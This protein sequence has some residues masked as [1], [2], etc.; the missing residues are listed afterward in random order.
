MCGIVGVISLS[1]ISSIKEKWF[2]NALYID[3]LRGMH[4]TGILSINSAFEPSIIKKALPAG[5][6]LDL[7]Q[8][9][10]LFFG[11]HRVLLGHN[12]FASK[13]AINNRNAHPFTHDHITMVHNGTLTY[14]NNLKGCKEF[15]VDSEALCYS[16][17]VDG[18]KETLEKLQG[19]FSIVWWDNNEKTMNF[20]RNEERPMYTAFC[21]N[22]E[23]IVFASEPEIITWLSSRLDTIFK[24]EEPI[25]TDAGKL[26]TLQIGDN[27]DKTLVP[28]VTELNLESFMSEQIYHG[29]PYGRSEGRTYFPKD[30]KTKD[31]LAKYN[32]KINQRID[33]GYITKEKDIGGKCKVI[34]YMIN[35][36]Y[37]PVKIF[38]MDSRDFNYDENMTGKIVNVST[39]LVGN[40][41]ELILNPKSIKYAPSGFV[42]T[43]EDASNA[44]ILYT[45]YNGETWTEEEFNNYTKNGCAH[46]CCDI[47]A[48]DCDKIEWIMRDAVLCED[49][50]DLLN[51]RGVLS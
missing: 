44:I 24:H 30:I 20:I 34:G 14:F 6:F 21:D 33:F 22:N 36:P 32:I 3:A 17:A 7:K 38:N 13:G 18:A 39:K 35:S 8:V 15:T 43:L 45:G 29:N 50:S 25:A 48:S 10:K 40:L 49:C 19:S 26:Y 9:D 11:Q 47:I 23:T 12:R 31:K 2:K 51:D 41:I 27:T 4:S 46:C 1:K 42:E 5:D 37:L 16:L 28:K